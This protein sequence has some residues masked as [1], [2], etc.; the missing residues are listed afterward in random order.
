MIYH[1]GYI[2]MNQCTGLSKGIDA[3]R[4]V[5]FVVTQ[6]HLNNTDARYSDIVLP[7]TTMWERYG[8]F[9]SGNRE[10]LFFSSQV[11]D[12]LFEAQDDVWVAEELAK[13]LGVDASQVNHF[14]RSRWCSTKLVGAKVIK[15]DGSDYEPLVTITADDLF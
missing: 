13:R 7:I 11:T 3:H 5:E 10:A 8:T 12:P 6:G 9:T 1:G 15:D 2:T 14:R 4:K